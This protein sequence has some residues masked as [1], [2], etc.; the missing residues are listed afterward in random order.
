MVILDLQAHTWA[1]KRDNMSPAY[2]TRRDELAVA[3]T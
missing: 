1:I 3:R 2:T